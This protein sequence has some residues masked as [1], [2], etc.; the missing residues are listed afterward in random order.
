MLKSFLTRVT[1]LE[2]PVPWSAWNA[3]STVI[4][5]F[6]AAVVCTGVVLAVVGV[7]QYAT[8]LSWALADMVIV[9]FVYISRRTAE[10]RAAL[11]LSPVG[12]PTDIASMLQNVLLLLLVG[13]GLAI[14]LDV[15]TGRLTDLSI[16]EPE[17]LGLYVDVYVNNFPILFISWALAFVMMVVLQPLAEELVFRGILQPALRQSFG[18]WPGY[19]VSAALYGLFHLITYSSPSGDAF[20]LWY[21]L[22]APF[23]AGLI[24]GAVRLY[25]GSTRAAVLT[26]AAFGLFALVKLLTLVG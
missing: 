25:T 6:L 13:V 10:Q 26:H 24:F 1:A 15:I 19:L 21:G 9:G 17:L 7:T 16:P 20:S 4:A 23:I 2:N 11:H 14:A 22:L 18:L 5:A 8:L 12:A 3:F